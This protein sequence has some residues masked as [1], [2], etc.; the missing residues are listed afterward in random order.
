MTGIE[1]ARRW[2]ASPP[3]MLRA[4][5][6]ESKEQRRADILAA[7]SRVF[8]AE[9]FHATTI[10][11]VARA[12]DVSYGLVYR[13]FDSKEALFH[14]LMDER[15]DELRRHIDDAVARRLADGQPID[16][17]E[18]LRVSVRATFEFFESDRDVA[19]LLF[20]D[21]LALGER[22]DRHLAATYESFIT[23]IEKAVIAA[24]E[25]GHVI[26]A[27]PR[28]VAVSIA[29]QVSQLALRRLSTDDGFSADVVADLAVRLLVDGLRPR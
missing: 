9:G 15:T 29:A 14:A 11:A 27:P 17:A 22:V 1:A 16:E 2:A 12:A 3:R 19:R 4:S 24:Q 10:K 28:L 6:D 5:S 26:D 18:V 8:A 20:R 23:D 21:A 7:A 13:Y 25:A